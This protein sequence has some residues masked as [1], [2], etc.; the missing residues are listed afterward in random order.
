[1]KTVPEIAP[2]LSPGI[3]HNDGPPLDDPEP[4][5]S[6]RRYCWTKAHKAAW[7]TPPREIA[8]RRLQR[9]EELGI[10]YHDYTAEILDTGRFL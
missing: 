5:V 2:R 9:A 10:S 4:G 1:V 6:W 7:K 3:G 8:L